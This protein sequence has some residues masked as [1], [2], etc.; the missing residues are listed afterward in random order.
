MKEN[1]LLDRMALS[2]AAINLWFADAVFT[3]TG[4]CRHCG[5]MGPGHLDACQ[6]KQHIDKAR[7]L[8]KEHIARRDAR[9]GQAELEPPAKCKPEAVSEAVVV[10][11]RYDDTSD[12]VTGKFIDAMSKIGV[13]VVVSVGEGFEEITIFPSP[14]PPPPI[15]KQPPIFVGFH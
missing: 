5:Q 12:E 3:D 14:V 15:D 4:F 13:S 10:R 7:G 11:V 9:A 1:D 6:A 8:L 2:L